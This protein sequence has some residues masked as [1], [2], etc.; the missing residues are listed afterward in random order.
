MGFNSP[1]WA[2]AYFGAICNDMVST[3]IYGTNA[4]EAC[5]YQTQHSD[6]EIVVLETV[7]MLK[8]FTV[9]LDQLP[10]VK[11]FVV[12]GESK[13]PDEFQGSRYFTWKD[14][15]GLG[16]AIGDDVIQQKMDK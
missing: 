5:L 6:A 14:F 1:E 15:M 3:G 4:P 10:K 9:N 2:V 8:R 7:D 12:W 16:G 11:A 13:L